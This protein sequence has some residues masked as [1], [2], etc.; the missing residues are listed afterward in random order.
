M[1]CPLNVWLFSFVKFLTFVTLV[2]CM[3][4][5]IFIKIITSIMVKESLK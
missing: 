2:K 4:L 5:E 3:T 1:D